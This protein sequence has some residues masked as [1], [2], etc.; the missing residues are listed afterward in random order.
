MIKRKPKKEK[1]TARTQ[2]FTPDREAEQRPAA[3]PSAPDAETLQLAIAD[4]AAESWRFEQ[5]LI[6]MLDKMDVMDAERFSRQYKYFTSRVD[7]AVASAGLTMLSLAGQPYSV[8]LPVQAMNL[9]SFDENDA[10]VITRV[11]EPV[12]LLDG[13]VIKTGVVMLDKAVE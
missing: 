3:S 10:L 13:R 8:G 12:I 5:A 7:K 11:I 9:E 6:K 4:I 2:L 1:N